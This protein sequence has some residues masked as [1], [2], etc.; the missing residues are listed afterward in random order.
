MLV[1]NTGFDMPRVVCM[2]IQ[3]GLYHVVVDIHDR[4]GDKGVVLRT[5]DVAVDDSGELHGYLPLGS[6]SSTE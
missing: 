2:N 4:T 6:G 5:Y 3:D 1:S